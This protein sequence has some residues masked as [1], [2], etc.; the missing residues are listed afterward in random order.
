M[1][2]HVYLQKNQVEIPEVANVTANKNPMD[3]LDVHRI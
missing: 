3:M 1:K 2:S